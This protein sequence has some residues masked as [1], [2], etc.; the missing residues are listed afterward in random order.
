MV[1]EQLDVL[2]GILAT[3]ETQHKWWLTMVRLRLHDLALS[4]VSRI[5]TA[6][7]ACRILATLGFPVK[8]DKRFLGATFKDGRWEHAG[9]VKSQRVAANHGRHLSQWR[10]R[11]SGSPH[12]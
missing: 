11:E 12:A 7:D 1:A 10:L 2:D 3:H 6:D 4:R 8:A 9:F 5:V